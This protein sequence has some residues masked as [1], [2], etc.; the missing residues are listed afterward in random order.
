MSVVHCPLCGLRF[1]LPSE[2][3]EHAREEHAPRVVEG[4]ASVT[5]ARPKVRESAL[6]AVLSRR[7]AA[8][9]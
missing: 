8:A 3:D 6:D 7:R 2:L 1:H 4:R 9:G 5:V